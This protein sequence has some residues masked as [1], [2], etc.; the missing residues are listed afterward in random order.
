MKTQSSLVDFT[1]LGALFAADEA[2]R[3]FDKGNYGEAALNAAG[4]IPA[5]PAAAGFKRLG[6]FAKLDKLFSKVSDLYSDVPDLP[7]RPFEEDYPNGPFANE[8]IQ[9]RVSSRDHELVAKY[10]AGRN[11]V[12][13]ADL[14]IAPTD[15]RVIGEKITGNPIK[16]EF[17]KPGEGAWI[18]KIEVDES[19][20]PVQIY[21]QS[22]LSEKEYNEAILHEV[23]HAIDL[24]AGPISPQGALHEVAP[25]YSIL[26]GGDTSENV[27]T[28]HRQGYKDQIAQYEYVA[29]AIRA[30]M[31]NPNYFKTVAP[32]FA[33]K[34]QDVVNMHPVLKH[35]IQFNSLLVAAGTVAGIAVASRAESGSLQGGKL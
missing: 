32:I 12:G 11:H 33:A 29:E 4:A 13:G 25:N 27:I 7:Q 20:R 22:G 31:A 35:I 21:I 3:A 2:K 16:F 24:T 5:G 18:G 26:A 1:P 34:I 8:K 15:V 14:A 17:P 6:K 9:L 10:V 30:Y 28:P 23:A 19:G